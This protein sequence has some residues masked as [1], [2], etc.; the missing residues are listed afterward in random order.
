MSKLADLAKG[1]VAVITGAA[2]GIGLAAAHQFATLGFKVALVDLAG[3]KLE[4]A[5]NS[6]KAASSLGSGNVAVYV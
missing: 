2:S 4:N 5:L 6:V 3:P 1:G